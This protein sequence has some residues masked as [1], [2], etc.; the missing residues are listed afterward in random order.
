MTYFTKC[1]LDIR[2]KTQ[3]DT[4]SLKRAAFCLF[5]TL[6]NILA[7][8]NPPIHFLLDIMKEYKCKSLILHSS[9]ANK[10]RHLGANLVKNEN[11]SR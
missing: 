2:N 3:S 11:L 6:V 1:L 7:E 8:E 5:L 9:N 4:M 10:L